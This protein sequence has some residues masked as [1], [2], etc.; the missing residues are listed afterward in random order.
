MGDERISGNAELSGKVVIVTGGAS[1]IGK[2]ISIA[3][4]RL[5]VKLVIVDIDQAGIDSLLRELESCGQPPEEQEW[6]IMIGASADWFCHTGASFLYFFVEESERRWAEVDP[7]YDEMWKD[8]VRTVDPEAQEA[9]ILEMVQYHYDHAYALL[10][11]SPLMLYA[12]NKAVDFVPQKCQFLTLKET[13]VTDNHWSV[14]EE[15]EEEVE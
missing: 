2:A 4:V 7:T 14:R 15:A 3:L 5:G 1:G 8:M 9:K 10:V 12:V 6:D 13:S 11:Y